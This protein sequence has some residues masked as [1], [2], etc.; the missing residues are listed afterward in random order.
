M[1]PEVNSAGH[2]K[3]TLSAKS[4]TSLAGARVKF[5]QFQINEYKK[6]GLS[7]D[8][9]VQHLKDFRNGLGK[10]RKARNVPY[11]FLVYLKDFVFTGGTSMISMGLVPHGCACWYRMGA[12][13]VLRWVPDLELPIGSQ[14]YRLRVLSPTYLKPFN[15]I[16]TT[17]KGK[18]E[19]NRHRDDNDARSCGLY[20]VTFIV[21]RKTKPLSRPLW[22][23]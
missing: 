14:R 17:A 4:F 20:S 22:I 2:L 3:M 16:K 12:G 10:H 6:L 23:S 9:L 7:D 13:E 21:R 5:K 11:H 15:K 18:H 8:E 1:A 19:P